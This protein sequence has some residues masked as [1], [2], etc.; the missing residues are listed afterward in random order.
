MHIIRIGK[1]TL[2]IPLRAKWVKGKM[3]RQASASSHA[4]LGYSAERAP[5]GI[6]P[7][8]VSRNN[9]HIY[10]TLFFLKAHISGRVNSK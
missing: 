1:L 6:L 5:R 8:S 9:K 4:R 2:V 7:L 3:M 10:V